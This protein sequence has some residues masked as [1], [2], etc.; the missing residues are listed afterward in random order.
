M[1][2]SRVSGTARAPTSDEGSDG[3]VD[4]ERPPPARSVDE[5]AADERPDRP[6][7]ATQP[8][9]RAD[10][11]GAVVAPEARLQ[12]RQAARREQRRADP[13]EHPGPDEHLDVRRGAA[14]QRRGGEPHRADHEHP[15]PAV[16]VAERT[17]KEDQRGQRQQV[18]REHPLQRADS[19]VEV[20]ADCGRATLTTVASSDAIPLA[21][22]VATRAR[23][24]RPDAS[25]SCSPGGAT[26]SIATDRTS[27]H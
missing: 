2:G 16:A 10:G 12:D 3:H 24:P 25:T 8:G 21:A 4:E 26:S 6:D 20:V 11:T 13:L 19:G 22:T 14:Q 27:R 9:P 7:H 23:R 15:A 1:C 17:T 18:A 5:P